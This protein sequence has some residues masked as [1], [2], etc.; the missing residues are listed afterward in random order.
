VKLSPQEVET[1]DRELVIRSN[2]GL[3]NL[4]QFR[5]EQTIGAVD[6]YSMR[7]YAKIVRCNEKTIRRS[8]NGYTLLL[9]WDA[10]RGA[11]QS[12]LDAY[13]LGGEAA[14]ASKTVPAA[15]AG[16]AD[17]LEAVA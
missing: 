14:P 3:R 16:P 12:P 10:A 2:D 11:P 13:N 5:Y 4:M 17:S 1:R 15:L 7:A 6:G 9:K 8:V